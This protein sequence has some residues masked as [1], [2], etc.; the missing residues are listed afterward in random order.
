MREAGGEV[1]VKMDAVM[2]CSGV[3][4]AGRQEQQQE[5]GGDENGCYG[6]AQQHM[7]SKEAR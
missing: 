2:R 6:N 1:V 7:H 4:M 5:G 3:H